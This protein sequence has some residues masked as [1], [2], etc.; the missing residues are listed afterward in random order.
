MIKN[1]I[2]TLKEE[3]EKKHENEEKQPETYIDLVI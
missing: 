2:K 1:R 3:Y